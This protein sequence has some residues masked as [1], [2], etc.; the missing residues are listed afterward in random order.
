MDADGLHKDEKD[1]MSLQ[2]ILRES[3]A[4]GASDLHIIAGLSPVM[5]KVGELIDM[6]DYKILMPDDTMHLCY[7]VMTDSQRHRFEAELELDF[8]FGISG[9]ARF[10]GN[11]SFQRGSVAG[12]FRTIP[13]NIPPFEELGIPQVVQNFANLPKGMVLVTGP[14]GS[15]KSTTL[16]S[17]INKINHTK[18]AHIITIEDPIEFMYKH[19]KC[20]INQRE[21]GTDTHSFSE[22]LKRSLRQDPD[23]M[24][25]GEMRDLETIRMALRAAETGHLV[26]ATLHT[27]SAAQTVNRIINV[28]SAD[29]QS[30]VR[31]EL[32][33][34]LEGVISQTLL[35]KIEGAD[36]VMAMEILVMNDAI[37]NLIRE[38][39]IHQIYATMQMGQTKYDMKT[40][41]QS[42]FEL[43]R[44]RKVNLEQIINA[45]AKKEE[46]DRMIKR[47]V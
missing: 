45:S 32:S 23:I 21:V 31:T 40:M 47:R 11:I 37:R 18:N 27:N 10:R 34:V 6:K 3:V 26:F 2:S 39:K 46:L 8:S 25:V 20:V 30:Q 19:D 33:L 35:K 29:E 16:A 5:R 9:L 41:N 14:T 4:R 17:I 44:K 24:L 12:A 36:R 1:T 38:D 13:T 7:S 22:A 42:L 15:G 28:F 43:Y